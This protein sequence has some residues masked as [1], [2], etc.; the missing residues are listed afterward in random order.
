M[1][2]C[3]DV[4]NVVVLINPF[5]SYFKASSKINSFAHRTKNFRGKIEK[6][7]CKSRQISSPVNKP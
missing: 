7:Y 5:H 3:C 6:N 2:K 1:E 4:H